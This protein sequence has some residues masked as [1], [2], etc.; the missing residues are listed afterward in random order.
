M[1]FLKQIDMEHITIDNLRWQMDRTCR[2]EGTTVYPAH[3]KGL[4]HIFEDYI[5]PLN[6]K[7]EQLQKEK[8]RL[9]KENEEL[10]E[11]LK[12]SEE[13]DD[14]SQNESD[15]TIQSYSDEVVHLQKE[16]EKLEKLITKLFIENLELKQKPIP[17]DIAKVIKQ[18][19]WNM[20]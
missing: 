2:D 7:I 18:E 16:N 1:K 19:F 20:I 6:T 8:E 15:G 14:F 11:E 4:K 5:N 12:L 13:M 17:N 9:V 3:E 10:K